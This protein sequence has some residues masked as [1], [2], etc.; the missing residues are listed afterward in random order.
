MAAL[1]RLAPPVVTPGLR[2]L[3]IASIVNQSNRRTLFLTPAMK[4]LL[5]LTFGLLLAAR[6]AAHEFWLWP[7]SFSTAPGTTV[8]VGLRV[9]VNFS[10]EVR[11][12]RADRAAAWRHTSTTGVTDLRPQLPVAPGA[13]G[14][15]RRPGNAGHPRADLRQPAEHH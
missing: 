15:R 7:E 4:P 12:F 3:V 1:R 14:V 6:L 10:G 13:G 2:A 8:Q 9:G 5:V 11:P